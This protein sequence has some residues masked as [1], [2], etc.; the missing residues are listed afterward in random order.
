MKHKTKQLIKKPVIFPH[1][2]NWLIHNACFSDNS[3]NLDWRMFGKKT[4][5]KMLIITNESFQL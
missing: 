4:N 2:V 5:K 1:S 3:P